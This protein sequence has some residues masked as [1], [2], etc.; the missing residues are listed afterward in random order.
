MIDWLTNWL[1]EIIL[2]VLLASFVDLLLP[3]SNIQKYARF[4][5]G[6]LIILTIIS[7]IFE[8]FS[9][10]YSVSTFIKGIETEAF[11]NKSINLDSSNLMGSKEYEEKMVEQV[12]QSM[13]SELK[14]LLENKYEVTIVDLELTANL[15]NNNWEIKKLLLKIKE[16]LLEDQIT[17]KDVTGIEEISEI[18]N[19]VI[20]ISQFEATEDDDKNQSSDDNITNALKKEI[21]KEWGLAEEI[22]FIEILSSSN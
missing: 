22:I 7:P 6:L 3:K 15:V 12:E 16:G 1:K 18:E 13:L 11:S 8:L 17:G 9:D 2:I 21:Q 20:E 14:V 4:I 10:N 19:I 5:L